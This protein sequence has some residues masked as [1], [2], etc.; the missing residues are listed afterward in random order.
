[1]KI[2]L[3]DD[4][5][6]DRKL[7]MAH[8]KKGGVTQEVLQACDGEDGLEILSS[9]FQEVCL[10]LLDWQMPRMDGIEF[11]KGVTKVPN[12]A[13]IPIIM[14]TASGSEDKKKTAYEVNPDLAGYLVKPYKREKLVEMITPFLK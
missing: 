14:V 13:S 6:M 1:M 12:V 7:L 3:V 5:M 10:I 11:M 8:L 9:H 4:S 2:L